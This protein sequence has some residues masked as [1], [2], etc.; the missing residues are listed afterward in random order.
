MHGA[1]LKIIKD[2]TPTN[3]SPKCYKCHSGNNKPPVAS[4]KDG[5]AQHGIY[6]RIHYQQIFF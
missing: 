3:F 1:T 5:Q 4:S 2:I 6:W